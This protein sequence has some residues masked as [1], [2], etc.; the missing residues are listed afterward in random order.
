MQNNIYVDTNIIIDICDT[1]RLSHVSSVV[2][3]RKYALDSML[4]INS[5]SLATLFYILRTQSK[6]SFEETLEK[7]Y[8]VREAF[9]LVSIDDEIFYESLELCTNKKC[10]DF[11]DAVQYACA[12]KI[13][14]D[15]IVTN[16]KKFVSLD[17]DIYST[18]S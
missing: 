4:Y 17:I 8:F 15:L 18:M 5:D 6:F 3:I 1:K 16:D 11:E 2:F 14:A 12:K 9:T 10:T 7:M 13:E